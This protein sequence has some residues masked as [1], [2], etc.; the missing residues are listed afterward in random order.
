M[1]NKMKGKALI[2]RVSGQFTP[3]QLF[4]LGQFTPGQFTPG[5][6]APRYTLPFTIDL[7]I[8]TRGELS[9][10]GRTIYPE[11]FTPEQFTPGQFTP[12]RF[13]PRYTLH[14]KG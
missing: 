14:F 10:L 13:T 12:G 5:R 4:T 2:R 9:A 7:K 11:Q 8:I 3:G 1:K 6:F